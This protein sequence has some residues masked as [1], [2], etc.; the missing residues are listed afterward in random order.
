M[1]EPQS[2]WRFVRISYVGIQKKK[3]SKFCINVSCLT[4]GVNFMKLQ[5][6][7]VQCR[8]I[9]NPQADD[10]KAGVKIMQSA[11]NHR[12]KELAADSILESRT[13]VDSAPIKA[14]LRCTSTES[15]QIE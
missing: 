15:K 5:T 12:V 3:N 4:S 14:L 13:K 10:H 6:T 2:P 8:R 1:E 7:R 9:Y 11:E